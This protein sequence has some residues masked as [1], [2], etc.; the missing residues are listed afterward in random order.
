MSNTPYK[1]QRG[2]RRDGRWVRDVP[3][4]QTIMGH[5]MPN[6]TDCECFMLDTFDITELLPYL[7]AKNATHPDYK[8]TV[9]HAL[10]MCVA[11]MIHERPKMNR[12]VQGRRTYERFEISLSFVCKRRFQDNGEEA[13]MCFVPEENETLDTMSWKIA[14]EVQETRKSE[15][16]T[17]GIDALVDSF[18]KIPRLIL[19]PVLRGVRILDFWGVNPKVLTDGDPN[20]STVLLSNLGSIQAPAVYH[21]LNNYGTN[22]L[23]ITIGTIRKEER[24]VPDGTKQ[25]RDVVDI[26]ATLDERIANGFYFARSLKLVQH[27]FE[28]PELLDKPLSEPSGYQYD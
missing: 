28:H 1:R 16:S 24:I 27:I 20:Y 12:F 6:R 4:L 2:D 22:S 13:L 15:S 23:M 25:M 14:G 19:M 5:I 8:T 9:F 26:G 21:H 11:R 17:G 3:G 18:A 7:D 10:I